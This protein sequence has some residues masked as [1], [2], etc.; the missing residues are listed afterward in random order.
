MFTGFSF[1]HSGQYVPI[2]DFQCTAVPQSTIRADGTCSS[3]QKRLQIGYEMSSDRFIR[4]IDICFDDINYSTYYVNYTLVN[5]IQ[6]RQVFEYGSNVDRVDYY[7]SL[8]DSPDAYYTCS[9]Q[10]TAVQALG[11]SRVNQYIKC[12]DNINYVVKAHLAAVSDFVYFAQQEST[13]QHINVVP[14][15]Y[16]IKNGNWLNLE[17]EIRQYA[18]N[19]SRDASDLVIY[20]GTFGVTNLDNHRMYL[21]RDHNDMNVVPVPQWVWKLVYEPSTKEG[22][23]FLVVNN[24][25]RLSFA[26]RCV[27]AQTQWTLAWNR[28]DAYKGYVYCCTVN[29]FRSVF[30]GLP[31]FEVTGL[32]TK[33]RPYRPLFPDIPAQ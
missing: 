21:G 11:S 2:S 32:L 17:E 5:G 22:I 20:S 16:S 33:N 3:S 1:E 6:R 29:N 25:Y 23:V 27:C 24:P 28:G 9:N 30:S 26:C 13:K 31:N 18:S 12:S 14:M 15:W 8:P 7:N 19:A 10:R 4:L